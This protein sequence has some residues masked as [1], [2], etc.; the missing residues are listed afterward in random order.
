MWHSEK[1]PENWHMS[2]LVQLFK[3]KGD[4]T[5]LDNFRHIHIKEEIPK[6]FGHLVMSASRDRL[7]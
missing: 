1:V 4:R 2:T 5:V 7:F 3:G 6:L